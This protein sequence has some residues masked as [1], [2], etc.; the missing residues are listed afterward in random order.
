MGDEEYEDLFVDEDAP[1]ELP[2]A[3]ERPQ[4]EA[5][6]S[7][8]LEVFVKP[9]PWDVRELAPGQELHF[10]KVMAFLE[11]TQDGRLMIRTC[12]RDC[13]KDVNLACRGGDDHEIWPD[14]MSV[15]FADLLVCEE[16]Y[17]RHEV[18]QER[19]RA[20]RDAE[21][22]RR[23]AAARAEKAAAKDIAEGREATAEAD[24]VDE[25]RELF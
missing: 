6:A 24:P 25:S 18:A 21:K 5:G 17:V 19:R 15:K 13:G 23:R 20:A 2:A 7:V 1:A 12:C 8:E 10:P 16:C 9:D 22:E 14:R 4:L 11:R 3:E